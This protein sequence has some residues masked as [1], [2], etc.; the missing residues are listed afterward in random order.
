MAHIIVRENEILDNAIKRFKKKV[1]KEGILKDWK[2]RE[3]FEKPSIKRHRA[4]LS[5]QRRQQQKSEKLKTK[6]GYC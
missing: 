4:K 1:E 6:F 2:E 3:F 5:A